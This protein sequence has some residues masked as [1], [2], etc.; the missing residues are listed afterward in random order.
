MVQVKSQ[1]E[2]QAAYE[3][4]ISGVPQ[5]YQRGIQST[6][7]WKEAA[8][9]GQG[10]Y[11]QRMQDPEVLG[12]RA[13]G[14]ERTNEQEWKNKAA[15]LG[16]QRIAAGM[17]AAAGKQAANYEPI[18]QALRGVN[19]PPRSADPMANIDARVKPIVAAAVNASRAR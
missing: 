2:R 17:Q 7:G 10:L 18:A 16:S 6:T 9:A 8:I 13:R 1:A 11:E 4:A 14:L 12:K 15:T 19:L 5:K 3:S